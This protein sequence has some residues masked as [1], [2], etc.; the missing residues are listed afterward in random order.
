MDFSVEPPFG[1]VGSLALQ[2][3]A[4]VGSLPS[5]VSPSSSMAL[6]H[7]ATASQEHTP[8]AELYSERYCNKANS[9]RA[10]EDESATPSTS[11]SRSPS[12]SP[13]FHK[14]LL[15]KPL[16]QL[17]EE[18]IMHLTREDCRRYLKQKGMRRPSW[19]KSQAIQ[20]V[21]S[22]KGLF[23]ST[24]DEEK[25]CR[26]LTRPMKLITAPSFIGE[27]TEKF[28]GADKASQIATAAVFQQSSSPLY[29][30]KEVCA[31]VSKASQRQER[32]DP[33]AT[34]QSGDCQRKHPLAKVS[35]VR[36]TLL[37]SSPGYMCTN[38]TTA[39]SLELKECYPSPRKICSQCT[40]GSG[41]PGMEHSAQLTIFYSGMVNV[42]DNVSEDQA[43]AVML[44][45]ERSNK[46]RPLPCSH[47]Q[48]STNVAVTTQCI[49]SS[50]RPMPQYVLSTVATT[51]VCSTTGCSSMAVRASQSLQATQLEQQSSRKAG[52]QRYLEK[53]RG[54]YSMR[55]SS[56][57]SMKR[58]DGQVL[59]PTQSSSGS[60]TS[61]SPCLQ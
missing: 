57:T 26:P 47:L 13:S 42:Y 32:K 25:I 39:T 58:I 33:H 8:H 2:Q 50:S 35:T 17:T 3:F 7:N 43:R 19:N 1:P 60:E 30:G 23:D 36:D 41:L 37:E 49:D 46:L 12:P 5:S 28:R 54:R 22:L 14:T 55:S 10:G 40:Q 44:L 52:L 24:D 29:V 45:A 48:N 61:S 6:L 34:R 59:L 51:E 27:D 11:P 56:A 16:E 18:D 15:D 31:N 4:T 21:L 9:V 53:R 20:Q 38:Q